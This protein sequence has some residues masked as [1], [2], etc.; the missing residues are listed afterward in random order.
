[1][2]RNP[3][4]RIS[5]AAGAGDLN[6]DGHDDIILGSHFDNG[7]DGVSFVIFGG[8]D[9]LEAADNATGANDNQIDIHDLAVNVDTGVLPIFVS[10]QNAGRYT[11]SQAEGD[12]GATVYSFTV[13]RT[14]DPSETVSFDYAV[15]G[16]G[17][18]GATADD[19]VGGAF[20]SGS[21]TFAAGSATTTVNIEVQGDLNIE[22]SEDFQFEISNAA[23]TG[24]SPISIEGSQSFGRIL[25]DDQPTNV[26]VYGTSRNEDS[27][28]S[29]GFTV[30]RYGDQTSTVNGDYVI[31]AGSADDNDISGTFPLTGSFTIPGGQFSAF[32]PINQ[33]ADTDIE[34]SESVSI[35]ISNVTSPDSLNLNVGNTTSTAYIYN[36]DFPPRI[37]V[38]VDDSFVQEGDSGTTDVT[39]TI[40]RSGDGLSGDV[41]V[42]FDVNPFPGAGDFFALN[43]DDVV[44]FLPSFGNVLTIPDG[45]A[46]VDFVVQIVGDGIIEPRESMI[47]DVTQ[48]TSTN[49]T[50]YDIFDNRVVTVFNDDGRPPSIPAGIEADVFGDPH[51]VTLDGLGYDFQAVGEYIL[52]ETEAGATNPFQVQVRFEPLPGSD[53]VSVTTRMAVDVGGSTVEVDALGSNAILI[54]GVA[55]SAAQ[56]ATGAV[57]VDGDAADPGGQYDLYFN[58]DQSEITV[59]LNDANEQLMIKNMDGVL[60]ICVFLA[61]PG[62]TPGGNAGAIQGLMGNGNGTLG[63]DY[64]L[65]DGSTIPASE[66]TT[67]AEG[68]PS[69]SFDYIYGRGDHEGAGYAQSWAL[70]AGERLFT[71]TATYPTGFPA[72][73]LKIDDLPTELRDAAEAAALAAGLDPAE[74]A[75][76]EAAVLDFALTGDADFI[77]GALGLAAEA[78]GSSEP[79][80]VP[81]LP[82]TVGV[83]TGEPTGELTEGDTGSTSTL[84]TFYRI[85]DATGELTV[86]Y[87]VGGDVDAA[88]FAAGTV[89]T[90]SVTFADGETSTS[91]SL[92]VSGDLTTEDDEDIV[93]SITGTSNPA[94]LV[95]ASMATT[96]VVTDDFAPVAEDDEV[97]GGENSTISGNVFAANPTDQDS[98]ADNDPLM[99]LEFRDSDGNTY[100]ADGTEKTL[101]SGALLA[102][103]ANGDFTFKPS[104]DGSGT[105]YD[106]LGDGEQAQEM[107]VYV[108][109][110]GNGGADEGEVTITINGEN[111]APV[112][113]DD[114]EAVDEDETLYIFPTDN[115][116][117]AEG[118]FLEIIDVGSASNGM[119]VYDEEG[120]IVYTPNPDFSGSDS[121]TYTIS[122]GEFTSMAT[123]SVTV[124]PIND[125][126]IITTEQD[127]TV[128]EN[129]TDVVSI[130]ATDVDGPFQSFE[131]SG[132]VD[133]SLFSIDE[134]SGNLSFITPPDFE[135]PGDQDGDNFY[136]VEVT[137]IDDAGGSD[138]LSLNVEVTNVVENTPPAAEDDSYDGLFE[139]TLV[140]DAANGVLAN[141]T[142]DDNDDLTVTEL[143]GPANGD[144][145][146]NPDG[147]FEYLP[148]EGFSGQDSFTYTVSDGNG[149]TDEGEVI[150]NVPAPNNE[151]PTAEPD[152][153]ST[154][155]GTSLT[156]NI[157]D[158][159]L[160]NDTDPENDTLSFTG[161][162]PDGLNVG[163]LVD[164]N[165]GTLTYTPAGG[166]TLDIFNY[167]ISDGNGNTSEAT[168]EITTG[169][170]GE[171]ELDISILEQNE[172]DNGI[173]E[174]VFGITRFGEPNDLLVTD[175]LTAVTGPVDP[176]FNIDDLP[177]ATPGVDFNPV[178][179]SVTFGPGETLKTVT[180][181]VIGDTDIEMDEIFQ[182][183]FA[184]VPT[185]DVPNGNGSYPISNVPADVTGTI[186]NDDANGAPNAQ[187]DA[188]ETSEEGLLIAN[189][190]DGTITDTDGNTTPNPNGGAD[191]DGENDPLSIVSATDSEGNALSVDGL[192]NDLPEG[193]RLTITPTGG[194]VFDPDDDF[195]DLGVDQQRDLAIN[196]VLSDG[197]STDDATVS[198]TVTGE[199]DEPTANEDVFTTQVGVP[200]TFSVA[201]I[202][203]NDTDPDNDDP[204]TVVDVGPVEGGGGSLVDNGD[205]TY[206]Y[207]PTPEA[208]GDG[209]LAV[210]VIE[211]S[212]GA[213][214]SSGIIF[215]IDFPGTRTV[216][217]SLLDMN[218]GDDGI[219]EYVFGMTRNS[220]NGESSDLNVTD[221]I[222]YETV[223]VDPNFNFENLPDATPGVDFEAASGSVT[224]APGEVFKS[225]T[226][227][228]FG[229]TDIEPDE[230][231]QLNLSHSGFYDNF[232]VPE[233]ATAIIRNDDSDEPN[234]PYVPENYDNVFIGDE[235]MNPFQGTP[236]DD[237]MEGRDNRDNINGGAG[238]D[239]IIA[240]PGNDWYVRGGSGA[241][242]FQFGPGDGDVKI[243]DWEDGT[244]K[245]RLVGGLQFEDLS[246]T[247]FTYNGVT[248]TILTTAT[249]DRLM[250]NNTAPEDIDV[251]DFIVGDAVTPSTTVSLSDDFAVLEGNSGQATVEFM[252][253]RSSSEGTVNVQLSYGGSAEFGTDYVDGLTTDITFDDGVDSIAVQLVIQGD[254]DVEPD[255]MIEVAI[256]SV[257]GDGTPII[258]DGDLVLTIINDDPAGNPYDPE[259]YDNVFIGDDGLNP[260]QGTPENDWIDGAGNRDNI[261]G[262]AGNDYIIAGPGNDWYVR[263]GEGS[264]IFQFGIGDGDIKIH[265]WQDGADLIRLVD[266]MTYDDLTMN[267]VTFGGVTT[268]IMSNANGD[269]LMFH[270]TLPSSLTEDDFI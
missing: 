213:Q 14:G 130:V 112:A 110:D 267:S 182:L 116:E 154:E 190:I 70:P 37:T 197:S 210:Y 15:S 175:T 143:V 228:V 270:N 96:T 63:D 160:A 258:S 141:D 241:D 93:V 218:E 134:F 146:L 39:F 13:Q 263:G 191:S 225:V 26:Y 205:G 114:E 101:P 121:F 88:D 245:V 180:V 181:E 247:S 178:D 199:N 25:N 117:D 162:T 261:N 183:Y 259:N 238:N 248:T 103:F 203:A 84:F 132:G 194:I 269:R 3:I 57:D 91:I 41:D 35:S 49:G 260:F 74:E 108:V 53:L 151:E 133:A 239:Y 8:T 214:S 220:V 201:D 18:N 192:F 16:F 97:G 152:T 50:T 202:L 33:T 115:D 2:V 87:L 72:A 59:V 43:S 257:S 170:P 157:A 22:N 142:D 226:V 176:N 99:V 95:G 127:Q 167:T 44:G 221:T 240:G 61:D 105:E 12:S 66:L 64:E 195:N 32:I 140:V 102:V 83:S 161:F 137:V 7:L 21:A 251:E 187:D 164:N 71:N 266:G 106:Q 149:G 128:P 150:L 48:V 216:D 219:T 67:D 123:V 69:L 60:N 46:S 212:Q 77:Q 54:D 30:Y 125:D 206:T 234:N 235:L 185:P 253:T 250:F 38:S 249:G 138:S 244:D 6:G 193:G 165:D 89:L 156:I 243:H 208:S 198:I 104:G 68:V 145:T 10:V 204:L 223:P 174:F 255:E 186:I 232:F 233:D 256:D 236:D 81:E 229:D 215:S 159:I 189:V 264:D 79:T 90:G 47:L 254:M 75:I 168:I 56:L 169:L 80:D 119:A 20:P 262:G 107:F 86:D 27:A 85:G 4:L 29:V 34:F 36:D 24:T 55:L 173:T 76:F 45:Q 147:S 217:V 163:E 268:T 177:D 82:T 148:Q 136:D 158:E 211:D 196:Y 129:T 227:N 23:T 171:R 51:I 78:A 224:F 94:A 265:D 209:G 153:F 237:W 230:I 100:D 1:M 109:E 222:N 98:D 52:V 207:T 155:F 172:G 73:S 144:L 42:T 252:I 135:L 17:S 58:E 131:I 122:D 124:N 28:Q 200:I 9:A 65:R 231:F 31:T 92:D 126:P 40:A 5:D 139:D 118:D 184:W 62:T 166:D 188:F 111:D 11:D 179:T 246:E 120:G 19:F 113:V 242:I